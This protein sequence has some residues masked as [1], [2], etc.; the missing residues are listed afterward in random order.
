MRCEAVYVRVYAR[1][2]VR[3]M[4]EREWWMNNRDKEG[5]FWVGIYMQ[6]ESWGYHERARERSGG[7]RS[8]KRRE[9]K[10]KGGVYDKVR[11]S[12]RE[13]GREAD[14]ARARPDLRP[15]L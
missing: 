2:V 1:A 14:Q 3:N 5:R 4:S 6:D 7:V 9:T 8:K 12:E 15:R 11:L 10:A 13:R